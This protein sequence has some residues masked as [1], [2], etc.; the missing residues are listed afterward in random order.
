M[1]YRVLDKL[2]GQFAF[3]IYD[4][5]KNILLMARDISGEKPLFYHL[6]N[7]S[8]SFSSE[9]KGLFE[10]KKIDRKIDRSSFHYYLQNGYVPSP[11][12]IIK[13]VYK[14]SPGSAMTIDLNNFNKNEWKFW[15]LPDFEESD[16]NEFEAVDQLHTLLVVL[17]FG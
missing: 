12:S 1:G 2:K 15:D 14:L 3:V 5:R 13:G 7:N 16:I 8:I 4:E 6:E 9:M 10:N 17:I 11:S